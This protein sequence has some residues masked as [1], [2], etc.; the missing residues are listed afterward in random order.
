MLDMSDFWKGRARGD[1][2]KGE[3]GVNG[4]MEEEKLLRVL[5]AGDQSKS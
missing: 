4:M 2:E 3:H 5:N 1:F